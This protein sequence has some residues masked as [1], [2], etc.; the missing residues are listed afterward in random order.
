MDGWL[1][2]QPRTEFSLREVLGQPHSAD[3]C[4]KRVG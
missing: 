3:P 1:L 4:G 2:A